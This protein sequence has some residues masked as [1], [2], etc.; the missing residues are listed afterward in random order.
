MSALSGAQFSW[1][2]FAFC[3]FAPG[4]P[5]EHDDNIYCKWERHSVRFSFVN[6]V[7]Y[8][9]IIGLNFSCLGW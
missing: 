3:R 4:W 5:E 9:E 1:H 7:L 6:F 2:G 8:K